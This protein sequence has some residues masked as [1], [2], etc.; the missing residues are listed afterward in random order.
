MRNVATPVAR[1][2]DVRRSCAEGNNAAGRERRR[3]ARWP[4]HRLDLLTDD[5]IARV[6]TLGGRLRSRLHEALSGSSLFKEVRGAGFMQGVAL[7]AP[8]Q[9]PCQMHG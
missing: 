8:D 4:R 1:V 9:R 6:A 5:L 2:G 7:R 3:D